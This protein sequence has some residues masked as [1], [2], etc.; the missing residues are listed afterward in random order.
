MAS[1][2]DCK[3]VGVMTGTEFQKLVK[4]LPRGDQAGRIIIKLGPRL[5]DTV[6]SVVRVLLKHGELVQYDGGLA[7]QSAGAKHPTRISLEWLQQHRRERFKDLPPT[8]AKYVMARWGQFPEVIKIP[9]WDDPNR[10]HRGSGRRRA[11]AKEQ[12]Q[13]DQ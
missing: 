9:A 2:A 11:K 6:N 7:I 4:A 10:P 13:H 5:H 3:A 12:T 1:R 8:L